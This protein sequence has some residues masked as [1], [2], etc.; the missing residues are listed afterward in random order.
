RALGVVQWLMGALAM[1]T[2]PLYIMSFSWIA[3]LIGTFSPTDAGYTGFTLARYAI[4]LAVMLPATFCAGMTLP[5]ITRTLLR[6]RAAERAIGAFYAWNTLGSIVGVIRA[7]LILLPALGLHALLIVGALVDIGIGVLLLARSGGG[8]P[9]RVRW[10][11]P[12][13]A[14]AGLAAALLAW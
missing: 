5:L 6:L 14:A 13:A 12:A 10:L 1:A 4:C 11:A 8:A 7:G 9:A 2:L 3:A